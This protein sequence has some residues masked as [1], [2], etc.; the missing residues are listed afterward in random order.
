[1][2]VIGRVNIY[3]ALA[4]IAASSVWDCHHDEWV[5]GLADFRPVDMRLEIEEYQGLHLMIDCY[6]ANPGSVVSTLHSLK[7]FEVPGKK[8]AVLGDMLEL[9]EASSQYHRQAGEDALRAG[10]DYL[11]CLGPEAEHIA[12]GALSSGMDKNAVFHFTDHQK[13]LDRLVDILKPGDLVLCKGSRGME[14]EKIVIG[15]KGSAFKN[16]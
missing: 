13:L 15:L 8:I 14:L 7:E 2:P 11:F 5:K 4:A 3:N 9:G 1:M 12:Q 6:N 10:V 16:N